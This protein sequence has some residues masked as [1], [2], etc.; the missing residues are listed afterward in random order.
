MYIFTNVVYPNPNGGD[1]LIYLLAKYLLEAYHEK[2]VIFGDANSYLIKRMTDERID[3]CFYDMNDD[4]AYDNVS[5]DDILVLFD[6]YHGLRRF[7]KTSCRVVTWCILAPQLISWNNFNDSGIFMGSQ[8]KL[9][10]NKLFLNHLYK[11]KSILSMDGNTR[12]KLELFLKKKL[13][14]DLVP[15]PIEKE[16]NRYKAVDR[17]FFS[18]SKN[19]NIT[20][21]GRGDV[22]WKVN[23]LKKIITDLALIKHNFILN[24]YTSETPLYDEVLRPLLPSNV[25]IN[26]FLGYYGERLRESLCE[27]SDLNFSMGTSAL[28][29]AVAGIP[30]ILIDATDS[31]YPDG[32]KYRWLFET[33]NYTLGYFLHPKSIPLPGHEMRSVIGMLLQDDIRERI[34]TKCWEYV[35]ENHSIKNTVDSLKS[36]RGYVSVKEIARYTPN[37]WFKK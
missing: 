23:P 22:Y 16:V 13:N 33:D 28:E 15:I 37:M 34:S 2:I 3:Y 11:K 20:Y 9:I 27:V 10:L 32:Y 26:F 12:R 29:S 5:K 17:S 7:K 6:N 36:H 4:S 31:D 35:S 19:I 1:N 14:I 18:G 8:L 24:I 21:I 25:E 30:T